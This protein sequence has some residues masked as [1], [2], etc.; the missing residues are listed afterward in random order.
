MNL[1]DSPGRDRQAEQAMRDL[2]DYIRE[3][4]AWLFDPMDYIMWGTTR[5]EQLCRLV[6]VLE[7]RKEERRREMLSFDGC[8]WTYCE[9]A[10]VPPEWRCEVVQP[11]GGSDGDGNG[12]GSR[13]GTE[14]SV[15]EGTVH[16]IRT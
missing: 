9:P 6:G 14:G 3:R 7:I 12:N 15:G 5:H 8:W 13:I 1:P 11:K 2:W 16:H 10:S 4:M